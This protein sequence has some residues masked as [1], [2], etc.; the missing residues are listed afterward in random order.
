[1]LIGAREEGPDP[2]GKPEAE[3]AEWQL[4]DVEA[5]D[6]NAAQEFEHLADRKLKILEHVLVRLSNDVGQ[7]INGCFQAYRNQ[8]S[9]PWIIIRAV[10]SS[11]FDVETDSETLIEQIRRQFNNVADLRGG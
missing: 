2:A 4:S 8:A 9:E 1:V 10:D 11:A 3:T 6:G 5:L 7:V